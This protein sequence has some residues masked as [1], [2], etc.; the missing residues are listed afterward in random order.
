MF[1]SSLGIRIRGRSDMVMPIFAGGGGCKSQFYV[2]TI[3][4]SHEQAGLYQ[5]S[6]PPFK[7]RKIP[8]PSDEELELFKKSFFRYTIAYGLSF[9]KW[10]RPEIDFPKEKF[11]TEKDHTITSSIPDKPD[12]YE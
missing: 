11:Y 6:V 8:S 7:I 5:W 4:E 3:N 1:N 12:Y 9:P 2:D 10:E